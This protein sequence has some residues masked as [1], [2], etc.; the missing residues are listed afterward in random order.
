MMTTST[1]RKALKLFA[2]VALNLSHCN[3][4]ALSMISRRDALIA[5]TAATAGFA[6]ASTQA[7]AAADDEFS[8][9]MDAINAARASAKKQLA[10]DTPV[11]MK[12]INAVRSSSSGSAGVIPIGDPGPLLSIRGKAVGGRIKIPRVGYSLYKTKPELVS[13]STALALRAGIRHFDLATSYGTTTEVAKVLKQ[14]LANGLPGLD[15]TAEKQELL[16][17]LDATSQAGEKHISVGGGGFSVS[18]PPAGSAGRQGRRT[19]LFLHH[20]LSNAEQ[21]TD[22]TSVNRAVKSAIKELGCSYLD[23]VSI[24]SPLT[25]SAR[26]LST[27]KALLGLKE[28][29]F[30]RSVGVCNYGLGPLKEIEALESPAMNLLEISPFNTHQ[31]IVNWCSE[32]GTAIGCATWSKLSSTEGLLEGWDI[33]SGIAKQKGMTKAQ[34]LVRWALQK[35]YVCVPRSASGSKLERIAIAENSYGGVNTA[36]G[37]GFVLTVEEMKVI[38]DLNKNWKAGSLGRTDGW[39][40][41]DIVG[42]EWDPTDFC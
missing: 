16:D 27:Y 8:V 12:T 35:G 34:V 14:Y 20:K 42:P 36:V 39:D 40:A 29:G 24:H 32:R 41:S 6:S 13:R 25:D 5:S 3:V 2:F 10:A 1:T 26:R 31:D 37:G 11:D 4:E 19:A 9:D 15:Y 21:S 23:M 28:A 38:D 30:I 18:P 22:A 7:G 33:L 17:Q